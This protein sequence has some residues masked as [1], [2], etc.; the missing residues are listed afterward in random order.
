MKSA[1]ENNFFSTKTTLNI[2]GRLLDLSV[3]RAMGVL[4]VTSDS[5]YDGGRYQT[6]AVIL[7][8]VE[9]MLDEG[10]AFIDVGACS[11]RPGA[12]EI[13]VKEELDRAIGTVGSI[14]KKFPEALISI[15][16]FRSKVA[17]EA[18]QAGASIVNDISGGELDPMM[19]ETVAR[20][21]V[22]YVVMHMKGNPQNM[23]NLSTYENLIKELIFYFQKK[24]HTLSQ[25]G[26]KDII[27][28]PGFGFAKTIEQNF[29]LLNHLEH[30]K[31]LDKP[32]LVGLSRKSM[33]WKT[34]ATNAEG[35]LNGTTALNSIALTK[36]ANILRVHDVKEAM[37]TIKLVLSLKNSAQQV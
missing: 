15:D 30:F 25:M 21:K 24:I 27:V 19:F 2:R 31:I 5:F 11:T 8:H 35:A 4:N 23:T 29:S 37:E 16:T 9:K 28:D 26:V 6:E 18:V 3:P 34:L 14:V 22:P 33:I 7:N 10:A 12:D 13:P 32:I 1:S 20:L 36:G 17:Y